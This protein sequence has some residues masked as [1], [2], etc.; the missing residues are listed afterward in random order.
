MPPKKLQRWTAGLSLAV[1]TAAA[2]HG[3][4]L[5][6]FT[7]GNRFGSFEADGDT[8]G[9][10]FTVDRAIQVTHLGFW[11]GD[12]ATDPMGSSHAVGLWDSGGALLASNTVSPSSP[13]TGD[14]RYEPISPTVLPA[15]TYNL[16]AFYPDNTGIPDGFM[17]QT[18]SSTMA[19]GFTMN[20]T[21]R[22]P[23]G[24]QTGL[25]FPSVATAVGGRY[26]PN[27]LFSEGPGIGLEITATLDG[28]TRLCGVATSISAPLGAD[29]F[30]C[31]DV[32]NT[33]TVELTRHTLVDSKAGTLLNDDPSVLG[34]LENLFLATPVPLS[35]GTAWAATWTA[36]NPGPVDVVQAGDT[37]GLTVA[38][39]PLGCGSG[40]ITFTGGIPSGF[41]SYDDLDWVAETPSSTDFWDLAACG[42][43]GNYTGCR[44]DVLCASSDLGGVG[45]YATEFR[46]PA[47]SLVG[48]TAAELRFVLNYQRLGTDDLLTVGA[49]T[50]FGATWLPLVEIPS[51]QGPFRATGGVSFALDLADFLD[52]PAVRI[53]FQYFNDDGEA[54]DG[55]VQLDNIFLT[56]GG[57]LFYD[58]FESGDDHAWTIVVP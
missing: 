22:D 46:T 14:W 5:V 30:P 9:W 53:R 24:P 2:A 8:L 15:G 12:F 44:G 36:F 57:E 7:G 39:A 1:A 16:G 56:C 51:S 4:A 43:A 17:S 13:M 47:F 52:E 29:V 45:P 6:S 27:L 11:D 54:S 40:T 49:S 19:T 28:R 3:Q 23:S 35:D 26:G 48:Q 10:R 42:E 58:D 20:A 33:G 41:T 38:P 55:Y 32:T 25:V 50:D 18:T 37:L 31:Y 34:V 21:L